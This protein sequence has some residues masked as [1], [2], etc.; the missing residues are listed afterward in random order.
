MVA[1]PF[2]KF[3]AASK[4]GAKAV[5]LEVTKLHGPEG[6]VLPDGT[7]EKRISY[8][9]LEVNDKHAVVEMV[10]REKDFLGYIQAAPTQYIY[11]AK[12]KKA[13]LER[14]VKDLSKTEE[15]TLKVADKEL[16]CKVVAGTITGAS[17]EQIEY[18]LWLSDEVPGRIAKQVRV[19]RQK[20]DTIAETTTTL[21]SFKTAE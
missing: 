16:K 1:N 4:P 8:K 13:S 18:K 14:I 17:G 19:T 11:P 20:G 7:D 2:Y 21:L 3:W 9:L 10:V 12:V 5:H 6:K 15:V